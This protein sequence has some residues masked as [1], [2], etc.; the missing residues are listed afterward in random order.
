MQVLKK[1]PSV[2][3]A[4]F[5]SLSGLFAHAQMNGPSTPVPNAIG[6]KGPVTAVSGESW[7]VHL[8]RP[9]SEISMGKTGHLT[10]PRPSRPSPR[11]KT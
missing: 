11:R 6:G 3:L 5:M 8:N 7:L 10:P 9:F 4:T 2:A 1:S